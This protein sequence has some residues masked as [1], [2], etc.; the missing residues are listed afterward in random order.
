MLRALI[1]GLCIAIF[2][3]P[4]VAVPTISIQE[5]IELCET[6]FGLGDQAPSLARKGTCIACLDA[7]VATIAQ[8]GSIAS[9]QTRS[10]RKL[11]FC[12]PLSTC[13]VCLSMVHLETNAPAEPWA[14]ATPPPPA[15]SWFMRTVN[16]P[17]PLS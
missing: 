10:P 16:V 17:F 1:A 12:L 3:T 4:W 8:V 11:L 15:I 2:A 7:V 14:R 9:S 6:G 5:V 13:S